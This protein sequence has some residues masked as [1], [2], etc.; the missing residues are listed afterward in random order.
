MSFK[1]LWIGLM[2]WSMRLPTGPR[3]LLSLATGVGFL[4][5]VSA[6]LIL[7]VMA[8]KRLGFQGFLPGWLSGAIGIPL[9][10]VGAILTVWSVALFILAKGTPVPLNPPPR[11]VTDGPYAYSRNP[12]LGGIFM[13]F[14]GAGA[15]LNSAALF[16]LVTPV[17]VITARIFVRNVEEPELETRL[18]RDYVEYRKKTPMFFPRFF[19]P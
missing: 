7:P 11:L 8:E 13:M 15:L 5:F 9:L 14:F 1:N 10:A 17:A 3:T 6:A 2:A 4:S 16:C 19:K 12:M 18:G